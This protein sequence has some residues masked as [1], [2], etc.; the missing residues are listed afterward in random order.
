MPNLDAADAARLERW[1]EP[2]RLAAGGTL[3]R[4]GDPGDALYLVR[5]GRIKLWVDGDGGARIRLLTFGR[6]G[7]FGEMALLD[8][9]PR[10]T[11]A[12]AEEDT[13]L[14]MLTRA[15]LD[16]LAAEDPALH[17][18]LLRALA[19]QLIDRLRATTVLLQQRMG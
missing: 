6:A 9:K 3:F 16:A 11:H 17:A 8:G 1:F 18:K 12:L 19:L 4:V 15:R 14:A 7:M 2:C 10:S 5:A 13:E